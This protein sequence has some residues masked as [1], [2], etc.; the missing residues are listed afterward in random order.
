MILKPYSKYSNFLQICKKFVFFYK[1]LNN[2]QH[3]GVILNVLLFLCY[4][5]KYNIV[6][7]KDFFFLINYFKFFFRSYLQNKITTKFF[8]KYKLSIISGLNVVLYASKKFFKFFYYWFYIYLNFFYVLRILF[9][10][11]AKINRFFAV[12]ENKVTFSLY[13]KLYSKLLV[14]STFNILLKKLFYLLNLRVLTYKKRLLN[15]LNCYIKFTRHNIFITI[16]SA[17][18]VPLL[19]YSSGKSGY[20]GKTK[21]KVSAQAAAKSA[22]LIAKLLMKKKLIKNLVVFIVSNRLFDKRIKSILSIFSQK[23]LKISYIVPQ[24]QRYVGGVRQKKIRRV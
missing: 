19:I 4:N 21:F 1:K 10:L 23:R 13:K 8:L 12:K 14:F 2:F 20:G 6:K 7:T 18:N 11:K 9:L 5:L 24:L 16:T 22:S 3:I 17:L 15:V